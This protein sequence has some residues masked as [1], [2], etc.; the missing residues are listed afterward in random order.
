MHQN[1][2]IVKSDAVFRRFEER[3]NGSGPAFGQD[4]EIQDTI[5]AS[6]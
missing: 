1:G 4:R 6:P 2:Q 3:K 5:Q